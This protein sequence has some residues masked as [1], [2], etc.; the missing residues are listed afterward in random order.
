MKKIMSFVLVLTMAMLLAACQSSNIEVGGGPALD[1]SEDV[2][3]N[4]SVN[5]TAAATTAAETPAYSIPADAKGPGDVTLGY[6]PYA[7]YPE[8]KRPDPNRK[9]I[10][11]RYFYVNSQG[12]NEE[13]DI[14]E[15]EKCN[16]ENLNSFMVSMGVL[17]DGTE[18]AKFE[19]DGTNGVLT[20]NQLEGQ[21]SFATPDLLAQA[22]AN[23]FI[24]NL[25]LDTMTIK[26]GDKTYGPLKYNGK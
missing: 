10:Q 9:Q 19:S 16:A 21:S 6:D 7:D 17:K 26:V 20:L 11:V 18:V 12:L 4:P 2:V 3:K 14:I 24:D 1:G 8:D 23:T 25:A 5:Q 13:F 22:I 15:E